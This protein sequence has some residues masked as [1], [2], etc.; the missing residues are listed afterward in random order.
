MPI[1]KGRFQLLSETFT[2]IHPSQKRSLKGD[3][4]ASLVSEMS[5]FTD[6]AGKGARARR[7][8]TGS[9]VSDSREDLAEFLRVG[10]WGDGGGL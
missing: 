3:T 9:R 2:F 10:L 5:S 1:G 7:E 4:Q 6:P 8:L